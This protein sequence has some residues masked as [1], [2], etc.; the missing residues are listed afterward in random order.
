MYTHM[1]KAGKEDE[2][3]QHTLNEEEANVNP[4]E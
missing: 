1:Y 4:K 3:N 2:G